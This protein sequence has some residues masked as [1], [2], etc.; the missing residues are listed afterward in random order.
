MAV[1]LLLLF[2]GASLFD[3][4][5]AFTQTLISAAVTPA[6]PSPTLALEAAFSMIVVTSAPFLGVVFLA[7]LAANF[8]QVGPLF[9]LKSRRGADTGTGDLFERLR[10]RFGE[11]ALTEGLLFLAK[12]LL[13]LGVF[14]F[15]LGDDLQALLSLPRLGL[16]P[17]LSTSSAIVMSVV[18]RT[19]AVLVLFAVIDV[20]YQ[21]HHY[22][23]SLRMTRREVEQEQ[24]ET[25]GDV[26]L[27]G[28][29]RR[30][31]QALSERAGIEQVRRA[32]VVVESLAGAAAALR[33]VPDEDEVPIVSLTGRGR[34][35]IEMLLVARRYDVPV[36]RDD[37][38]AEQLER[39][40]GPLPESLFDAVGGLLRSVIHHDG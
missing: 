2:A 12:V 23:R 10:Q 31:Q 27:R 3:N 8:V 9:T 24:R 38:L 7:G 6:S 22:H 13:L 26:A 11:R 28:E 5:R 15:T 32:T 21:R 33:Y 17:F 35:A 14:A 34:G 39:L 25:E 19:L 37:L 29:R 20:L 16:G 30:F 4:L 18:W 40:E 36:V 1:A